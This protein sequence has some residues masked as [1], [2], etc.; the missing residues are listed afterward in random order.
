M[1]TLLQRIARDIRE[2]LNGA[3]SADHPY[4]AQSTDLVDLERRLRALERADATHLL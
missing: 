1:S 3:R 4:L 2:S